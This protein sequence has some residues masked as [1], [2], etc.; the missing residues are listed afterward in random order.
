MSTETAETLLERERELAELDRALITAKGGTGRVVL[1]E[2][3]AGLGKTSLLRAAAEAAGDAGFTCLRAR[4][5]ELERDFAYGCV[6]QLL[7]PVV[8]RAG[9]AERE[10]LFRGAAA[11]SQPLFAPADCPPPTADGAFSV[12]H[13][14]YW[15]LNNL[16]DE[17][18]VA[19]LVDDLHWSD[20]ESLRLLNYL[21]P[22]LDGL[23]VA[24]LATTRPGEG[25][26][27][28]IARLAAAPE[29]T[30]IAPRPLS[31]EATA[32]LCEGRL[33]APVATE[34]AAACREATGGNPF[35]LEALL[36]DA[37]DRGFPT[38][39]AGAQRVRGT[40]PAAVAQA[41]LLRLEGR[42][43][44][45]RS[46]V[47]AAAVLG[48][49]AGIAEA[50]RLADLSDADAAG[51][52]DLLAALAI[53]KP[54]ERLEFAHPIVR[55]AVYAGIGPRERARAHARAARILAEAGAADERIAAQVVAADPE[56]DPARVELLRHVAAHALVQGAPAAAAAWLRRALAEPPTAP[57]TRGAVLLELGSAELRLG[58][59]AAAEHLAA[60]VELLPGEPAQVARSARQLA[61]AHTIAGLADR[62]VAVLQAAIELVEPADRELALVLE[63]EL[64]SH[65]R[66]APLETRAP[67]VKRLERHGELAGTTP[68]ERLVLASLACE[69]ARASDSAAQAARH[70]ESALAGGRLLAEQDVDVGGPFYD[71]VTGLL[72]AD[73]LDVAERALEQALADARERGSIPAVAY[74]TSRRGRLYL[75]RGAVALAEADGRTALELLTTHG[76]PLGL[77][78]SV[79]LLVEALVERGEAEAADDELRRAGLG[80]DILPGPTTNFFFQARALLHLARGRTREGLDDLEEFGR[81]DELW[82]VANPLAS[83]WR[84]H[85]ALALAALGEEQ[86][87]RDM[88]AEDLE[89]ARQWGTARGMGMALRA[90]ALLQGAP[91]ERLREAVDVLAGS[92]A[93]L[94]HARALV[95]LGAAMRRDNRRAEARGA[96]EEGRD[97][98]E[99]CGAVALAE[100]AHTE[101]LAAGGRSSD[102]FGD[103]LAQLTV[104]E[105]R[106]AE[107]AAKG[108]SNPEIAQALFVTRKTVET[109][110]GHV[111][112]K[113]DIAGRGELADALAGS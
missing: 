77:P 15:L 71:I 98:A 64:A 5:G 90:N 99:R 66:Q 96:L 30:A 61:L 3:S 107:L 105:R 113:L 108:R 18:P 26:T 17:G 16:A 100:T 89:R 55:E 21:A 60:A 110:L 81:R 52:A 87:A 104:S 83:R 19:L 38:D 51:A 9:G 63:G 67:A 59:P 97:L 74:L 106:V 88:A 35:F 101:L 84:S 44:A 92:S 103:G 49:G 112:R 42:P 94:E 93:R 70:L 72:A 4:A 24:V 48:D 65:A 8:A 33:G 109:H 1:V 34:F 45:A 14:L 57:E 91:V 75:R 69:R 36:R 13:G 2:A 37:A 29:T 28:A 50:A 32:T 85:A 46:L 7:E 56:G 27:A 23:A 11:L 40:G 20:T 102:P 76:I 47:R 111:Y 10:R 82:G 86:E 12:L 95:D 53:L 58:D 39:A 73:A 22:R 79:G 43:P 54:A 6:R 68:G 41:V 62:S 31:P 80:E 78:S 25:D